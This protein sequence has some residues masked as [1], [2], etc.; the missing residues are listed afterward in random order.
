MYN[1]QSVKHFWSFEN[2]IKNKKINE[3]AHSG[4][5][6]KLKRIEANFSKDT[7]QRKWDY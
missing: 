3:I 4:K 6:W 1:I 2:N 7:L 5:F